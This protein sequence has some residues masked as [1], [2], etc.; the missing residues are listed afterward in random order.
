MRTKSITRNFKHNQ[1]GYVLIIVCSLAALWVIVSLVIQTGWSFGVDSDH[2]DHIGSYI[3]GLVGIV[4]VYYLYWTLQSQNLSFR[5]SSF[6]ERLLEM[7]KLQRENAATLKVKNTKTA[8]TPYVNGQDAIEFFIIRYV[9]AYDKVCDFMSDKSAQSAYRTP[10]DYQ[11]DARIWSETLVM[12]RLC[13]N[14]AYLITFIGVNDAGV[15]LLKDKYLI[16]YN[17][18]YV[19]SILK[20]FQL[21]LAEGNP[22]NSQENNALTEAEKLLCENKVFVGFQHEFGNYFRQLYQLVTYVNNQDW[23]TYDDKYGYVKM[24]R[25]QLS[26]QEETLLF[27]NSLSDIG[28]A[29]EY[30]ERAGEKHDVNKQLI[31]KYNLFKNIPHNTTKPLVE[32]FYPNIKYEEDNEANQERGNLLN[33]Y[34]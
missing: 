27:Y 8:N 32:R 4:T 11:R 1:F 19:D 23:L 14:I 33:L 12:E 13:A 28:M 2:I 26:N 15:R 10:E 18:E 24:L 25:A 17:N 16:K 7:M 34:S 30:A 31:T 22:L 9:E 6:E 29:W 20:Q 5:L 3:G 21:M